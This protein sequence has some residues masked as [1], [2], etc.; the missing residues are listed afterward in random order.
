[1]TDLIA[2]D[3]GT[4][5]LRVA[6]LRADGSLVEEHTSDDGILKVPPGGF[7][8]VFARATRRWQ[9]A[10]GTLCLASG[11]VGSRQGWIEAPYAECPAELADIAKALMPVPGLH[12]T[13]VIPG[14]ES[15]AG[16]MPEVMRGEE[17]QVLGALRRLGLDS[18][19]FLLPGTHSKWVRAEAGRI[20]GFRTY[21]TGEIFAA[22]RAHTILGRLMGDGGSPKAFLRGVHEGA[23]P[24]GP[25]ALL[26]RL[27]GVR[28]AGLFGLIEP[29]GLADYLS[30]LLIGAE[31]ADAAVDVELPIRIIGAESLAS[32]YA[33]AAREL[34]LTVDILD[35]DCIAAGY[36]AVARSAGLIQQ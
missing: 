7:P 34:K 1:M 28:T 20:G 26:N 19:T 13:F 12:R 24:G 29:E 15:R 31:L 3:W 9:L 10:P 21:M 16:A 8:A 32:R 35:P 4:S 5:S 23:R 2:L 27:F 17:T 14:V 11:M 18:G 6:R 33:D 36:L 22:C 30:G 25:G